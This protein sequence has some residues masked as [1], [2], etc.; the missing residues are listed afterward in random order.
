MLKTKTK[1]IQRVL[2]GDFL[3]LNALLTIKL[4]ATTTNATTTNSLKPLIP[5]VPLL[6]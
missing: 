3:I 6:M 4:N 5:R 1:I 2:L